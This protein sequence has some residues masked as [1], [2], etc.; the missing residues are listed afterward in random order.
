MATIRGVAMRIL[1]SVI[2]LLMAV[3]LA[4]ASVILVYYLPLA[5][6]EWAEEPEDVIISFV[7]LFGAILVGTTTGLNG[8]L[9]IQPDVRN[10]IHSRIIRILNYSA[11][12]F[13]GSLGVITV[14]STMTS[15]IMPLVSPEMI[16]VSALLTIVVLGYWQICHDTPARH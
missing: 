1:L 13:L 9:L 10:K 5:F 8:T 2:S 12:T 16:V 15:P 7:L 4:I 11:I 6:S 3:L 14:V